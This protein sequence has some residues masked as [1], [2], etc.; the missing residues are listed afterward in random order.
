MAARLVER[1]EQ[2]GQEEADERVTVRLLVP[3]FKTTQE[4]Q[5]GIRDVVAAVIQRA[6]ER[7][8]AVSSEPGD[9]YG[10]YCSILGRW[11]DE[12]RPICYYHN[13]LKV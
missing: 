1:T 13:L 2:H 4:F 5:M 3:S 10:L 12:H 11:L 9:D 7:L 6:L 8:S